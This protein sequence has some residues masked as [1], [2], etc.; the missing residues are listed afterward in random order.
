MLEQ[1]TGRDFR[2]T[3]ASPQQGQHHVKHISRVALYSAERIDKIGD[4]HE[5]LGTSSTDDGIQHRGERG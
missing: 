2:T 5:T 1:E 3:P 4:Q